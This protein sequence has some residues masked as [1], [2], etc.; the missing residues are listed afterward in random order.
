MTG[1]RATL[2]TARTAV[3]LAARA[4]PTRADR[5]RYE[6]EFLAELHDLPSGAQL[7]YAA[8]VLSQTLAL[9]AALADSGSPIGS[10]SCPWPL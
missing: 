10:K 8:G 2:R 1:P 5:D 3:G 7:R 4:L 6:A 9:R